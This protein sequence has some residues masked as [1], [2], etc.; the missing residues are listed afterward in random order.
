VGKINMNASVEDD[1]GNV[2][3]VSLWS[4]IVTMKFVSRDGTEYELEV[5][6]NGETIDVV[7]TYP[8]GEREALESVAVV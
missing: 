1:K 7:M 2:N 3:G 5:K 8:D 4:D 6:D